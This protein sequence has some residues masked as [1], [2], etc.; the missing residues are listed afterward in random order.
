MNVPV[1]VTV[2]SLV[3]AMLAK[4]G[5]RSQFH[6]MIEVVMGKLEAAIAAACD[7]LL[8]LDI[9]GSMSETV[10]EQ[11][12]LD[13][14]KAACENVVNR[15]NPEDRVTIVTFDTSAYTVLSLTDC[16]HAGKVAAINAIY[17]IGFGGGTYFAPALE[18]AM[19]GL[20][21]S[22]RKRAVLFFTDGENTGGGDPL[23]VA[24][25]LRE[26]GISLYAGGL[27]VRN[28]GEQLLDQLAGANF[29]SLATAADVDAFLGSAAAQAA[30]AVVTNAQV[31]L[32]PVTFAQVS[33]F[34]LVARNQQP[35]YAPADAAK[36]LL[37]LGDVA[38]GDR[39][40]SYLG[41]NVV[42]PDD[43]KAGRRAF[44]KVELV[45][46]VA[47]LGIKGQV[48]AQTPIA[49]MFSDQPVAAVNET[50]K[51]M[52]NTAGTARELYLAGQAT[53]AAD[54]AKHVANARKTAAFSN[55]VVAAALRAQMGKIEE[56]VGKDPDAAQK[57][58]RRA[59]RGF[60]AED[61]AAAL[62]NLNRG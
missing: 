45:G 27:G 24:A 17:D 12:K 34:D 18:A 43:I 11:V 21:D 49:V 6:L 55:D 3:A 9:S 15:L 10:G 46:D 23:P 36:R 53:N 44:G 16:S 33:N 50:V 41:L 58:A 35:N 37:P 62:K 8:L 13:A 48:L 29:R 4:P 56:A 47:A 60:S 38:E 19:K 32:S 57:A 1:S 25:A 51:N 54:A 2:Q 22:K 31:R 30:S 7:Y 20:T 5:L 59:T 40:Q 52:I 14:L 61:A 42:L 28:V 39:Y 26:A